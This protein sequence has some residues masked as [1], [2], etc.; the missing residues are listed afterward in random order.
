MNYYSN[1]EFTIEE[2]ERV[3]G[4]PLKKTG[5]NQYQ[6]PCRY[7]REEGGDTKG[8]NLHFNP[9]KGFF[10]GVGV[11]NEHGKRLAQEIVDSRKT[12]KQIYKKVTELGYTEKDIEKYQKELFSNKE[13]L[14][15]VKEKTGLSE[16]V[17]REVKIGYSKDSNVFTLPMIALDGSIVG[18]EFRV[19]KN[20]KGEFKFLCKTKGFAQDQNKLLCKINSPENPTEIFVAAGFKDGYAVLQDLK[21]HGRENN[22]L[23]V[24]NSNGEP[25]TAKA[26]KPHIDFL[27]SFKE[28]ILCM[29]NDKAGKAA[30]E[31]IKQSIPIT[32]KILDLDRLS[33]INEY[34]NDFNDLLKYMQEHSITEDIVAN[35]EKL[36]VHLLLKKYIKYPNSKLNLTKYAEIDEGNTDKLMYF[37][38]GIY[39][40]DGCYYS[41]KYNN[42]NKKLLYA[43]KSNFTI[44]ITRKIVSNSLAFGYN[45]EYMLEVITHLGGKTTVP[46]VLTQ[47]D[48]LNYRN[49]HDILKSNEVHIN[50]LTEVELKNVVLDEL[51]KIKDELHIYKNPSLINHNKTGF[52]GI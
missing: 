28:A 8:D 21:N 12:K 37:E 35:N 14:N 27:R 15:L 16:D 1:G 2:V 17:I 3:N 19:P 44:E 34:I 51:K 6:G 47:K 13:M 42:E 46:Q 29:D 23:V 26:L 36:S 40:Y 49:L 10:C 50:T 31:K 20:E 4:Y 32:F 43:R 48:L 22:V 33:G 25:H 30:V 45:S 24:T 39:A 7:C 5:I 38:P 9:M 52:L 18:L 41:I 11:D